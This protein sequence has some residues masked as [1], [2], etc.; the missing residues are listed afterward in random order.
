MSDNKRITIIYTG[1]TISMTHSGQ[2]GSA[3]PALSGRDIARFV[4]TLDTSFDLEHTD[5]ERLPSP[6]VHPARMGDL[7]DRVERALLEGADGVVIAHGTDTLEESAFF[8]D[9]TVRTSHPV[10][11]VGAMRTSDELSWDGPVNLFSACMVAASPVARDHGVMV[12]MN[13]TINAA[14]E[15]TKSFTEAIDTFVSP[16]YGPLGTVQDDTVLMYRMPVRRMRIAIGDAAFARTDI[17]TSY[18]GADGALIDAAVAAGAR[19]L[20]V[21]AMG[22]GNLPPLMAEACTRAIGR[23]VCVVITS[24]CWGGRVAPI[25]GYAGGGR[26]LLEAGCLFA[27]W[28]N[29]QKAR[30]ALGL[31]LAAGAD[32]IALRELFDS[33]EI[34]QELPRV[35]APDATPAG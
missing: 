21:N 12:V 26:R 23:G 17:I 2:S 29:A 8:L 5:F 3:V 15:V 4:P 35:K 9:L 11:F 34:E 25:Y 7:R 20:V 16:E 18:A 13:N 30:I 19:G 31:A 1:G 6:H 33:P 24:R 32:D 22:K 14:S 28:Y 10:V 27:P